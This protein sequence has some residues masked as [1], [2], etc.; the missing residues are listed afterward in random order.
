MAAYS[1][2]TPELLGLT[3][4]AAVV[5]WWF[6]RRRRPALR[7]ADVSLVEGLPGSRGRRAKWGG[8]VLRG[9]VTF[10]V[11][12]A[13]AGPRRPD[14]RTPLPVE[15]IAIVFVLDTSG[16]MF[17]PDFGPATGKK[18]SRIDAARQALRL[19]VAG[20]DAPDG[21]HFPGRPSDQIGLVTFSGTA[22]APCPLTLEHAAPLKLLDELQPPSA[23]D[24]GSNVGDGIAEAVIRLD[25]AGAKRRKVIVLLS[26]GEHNVDKAAKDGPLT[27]AQAAQ[28]AANLKIPIYAI[29]P[30]GEP[31]AA[32]PD[33][34]QQRADG[35]K[36]LESVASAT[37]GRFFAANDAA[38]LQ[39]TL[40]DIDGLEPDP[41]QGTRYRRYHDYGPWVAATAVVLLGVLGLLER[42][43]WRRVP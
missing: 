1:F 22:D 42:T 19:F 23:L 25:A 30:G 16:S 7:F 37:G 32:P 43:A 15:G 28:L 40:R 21:T 4:L 41:I 2:A 26:D 36:V 6:A 34:R 13:A 33:Q 12:V 35:R 8:A 5:G 14:E 18:M 20:G 39:A 17:T 10:L 11:V 3:P 29:D 27:P 38:E 24:G 31:D 9:L